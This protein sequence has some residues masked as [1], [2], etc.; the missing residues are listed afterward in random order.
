[1]PKN[2]IIYNCQDLLVGPAED[3]A[4]TL[5]RNRHYLQRIS[6]IQSINYDIRFNR[7]D[8]KELGTQGTAAR[9]II[10]P[11]EV[12]FGFDYL[13]SDL[14]NEVRFGLNAFYNI[15]GLAQLSG[16]MEHSLI[17]NFTHDSRRLDKRNFY[18]ITNN[19]GTNDIKQ[20][21]PNSITG[22]TGSI[23]DYYDP[24]APNYSVVS[25]I[26]S[27]LISYQTQAAVNDFIR[28]NVRYVCDSMKFFMSGSGNSVPVLDVRSGNLSN[29][30]VQFIVPRH[31][32][33]SLPTVLNP[34]DISV[35]IRPLKYLYPQTGQLLTFGPSTYWG[36][37]IDTSQGSI[38]ELQGAT[39]SKP[40]NFIDLN[41][42]GAGIN[43]PLT[44]LDPDF[45]MTGQRNISSF[46]FAVY[47]TDKRNDFGLDL[48]DIK[49]QSY[50]LSFN[51]DRENL[52]AIGHRFPI[53]R[54]II[55]PV[56]VDLGFSVLVGDTLSGSLLSFLRGYD[57]YDIKINVRYPTQNA[58][59][60][61]EVALRYDIRGADFEGI[62]YSN[63]IG[64]SLRADINFKTEMSSVSFGRGFFVSGIVPTPIK[65]LDVLNTESSDRITTEAGERILLEP[66]YVGLRTF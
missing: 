49:I 63:A 13:V 8:L 4:V 7:F 2:R 56:N 45:E 62:S 61:Q 53:D 38:Y 29:T 41:N 27:Y 64:T 3:D 14:R 60:G 26:N 34:G 11:T 9:P 20:I 16:Y 28:S 30:D 22:V 5:I 17:E 15:T 57:G 21:Y 23:E 54:P 32:G 19:T 40:H 47:P 65:V 24:N 25:L 48:S 44:F 10:G 35:N 46:R 43:G 1:M 6:R 33:E 42:V 58:P 52:Q 51:I 50:N 55:F 59:T 37:T 39:L 12:V 18:I 66:V 31:Y 36:I